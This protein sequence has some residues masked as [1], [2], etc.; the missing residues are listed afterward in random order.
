[1]W[2]FEDGPGVELLALSANESVSAESTIVRRRD[3]DEPFAVYYRIECDG[4]WRVRSLVV[5]LVDGGRA[6][7]LRADGA[8]GW[9]TNDGQRLPGLDDAIDLDL[10]ATAFTNTLPVRRLKLS[11]GQSETI[12]VAYIDVPELTI[13][14]A[15]QRYTCLESDAD[16]ARYLFE[17][18]RDDETVG[19]SA[20]LELDG[21]GLV[22]DY[23]GYARR[24]Y[25]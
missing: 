14:R 5:E 15:E 16:R 24:V 3:G 20:E 10:S 25:G 11:R 9:T 12:V 22:I 7:G 8:G 19:Y 17:S 4:D 13:E 18:L 2:Q 21:D 1:M 6:L 23:P